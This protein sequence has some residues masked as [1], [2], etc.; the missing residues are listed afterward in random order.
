M[1]NIMLHYRVFV[2]FKSGVLDPQAE[3]ISTTISHMGFN[4][5]K[6]FTMGKFFDI[7]LQESNEQEAKKTLQDLSEKLLSNPVIEDFELIK[8]TA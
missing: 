4:A 3:A 2:R 7:T 6:S 5:V 1:I 8:I